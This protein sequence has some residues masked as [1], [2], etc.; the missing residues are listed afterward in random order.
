MNRPFPTRHRPRVLLAGVF[1]PYGVDD[2]WGRREN[3]MELFHNQVTRGQG[4]ASFRFHHRSFGLYFIAANIDADTTV[5]D[6][7]SRRRFIREL[8]KGWDVVGVSFIAPNFL[9]AREM[10]RLTR[11]HA[12]G[13][14]LVLGGHG[15]AIEGI[16]G[17]IDCD[18][19]VRGEGIGGMR[20]LLGQ[21]PAAPIVHPILPSAERESILGVP[22]PGTCSSLLVPGLGCVNGC[23]FCCTSHFFDKS[24]TSY[25]PTGRDVF[26]AARRIADARGTDA[27]FVMDENFLKDT[28]RARELLGEMERHGRFFQFQVFSSA[29]AVTAFGIDNLVRLGVNFLWMGVETRNPRANFA[30]NDGIDPAALIRS[31]RDRGISVLASGILCM[32]HH[33]PDNIGEDISHLVGLAADFVQF[34]LLTPMPTTTLY[35]DMEA[36]GRLDTDLPLEEVHGQKKLNWRHPAFPEDA[37]EKWLREAFRRDYEANSSSMYRVA[38][39]AFRGYAW[40]RDLP[41]RDACLEARLAQARR[42]AWDYAQILPEVARQGVNDLERRRARRLV[43]GI[44]AAFGRPGLRERAA[45][46]AIR[47]FAAWWRLRVRLFGDGIQP[48][49]I[50]TRRF[51]SAA[52]LPAVAEACLH[53]VPRAGRNESR[54]KRVGV[55][56]AG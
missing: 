39:T 35:R 10:A 21:D 28:G 31:L 54:T 16:E 27:F 23:R 36:S 47:V 56:A 7:P 30:K 9:K 49:T 33:T 8:K 45:R 5:L 53:A 38:E 4:T 6:F 26:Q 22:L 25:L 15:T 48:S 20:R 34:M 42:R 52:I 41:G 1:G 32:E 13:A 18:D 40:L 14:R 44:E 3:I 11:L 43:E 51:P 12:P 55:A 29:E 19:V 17:M 50:V 37:A 24:Y 46:A 2:A